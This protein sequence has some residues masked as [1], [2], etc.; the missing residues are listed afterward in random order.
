[1][2]AVKLTLFEILQR[3]VKVH[4]K[5]T[6]EK[7]KVKSTKTNTTQSKKQSDIFENVE[8]A[9]LVVQTFDQATKYH[10][11]I[12]EPKLSSISVPDRKWF[13]KYKEHISKGFKKSSMEEDRF[14]VSF[15]L[16]NG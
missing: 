13:F 16:D 3:D 8:E 15:Q 5:E 12:E 11:V 1:M 9:A 14:K 6:G 2:D 7:L 10:R 4:S